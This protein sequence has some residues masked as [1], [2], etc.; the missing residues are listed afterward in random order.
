MKRAFFVTLCLAA[1]VFAAKPTPPAGK[2]ISRAEACK[3]RFEA[4]C[5]VMHRCSTGAED[6]GGPGCDA[7]DPGCD[8]LQGP[9]ASTR[10][11]VEACVEGL[12]KVTCRAKVDPT[13]AAML[14]EGVPA[15]RALAVVDDAVS[16]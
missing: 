1:S 4:F 3:L 9:S 6:L 15:C 13:E 7:I 5:A 14:E 11:E 12:K 10:A 16:R 2:A 8:Q